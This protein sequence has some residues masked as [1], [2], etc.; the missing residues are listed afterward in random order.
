MSLERDILLRLYSRHVIG[1]KHTAFERV[2]SGIPRHLHG[3][4]KETAAQLIH[5]GL[6]LQ[7]P[8]HYGLQ[9]SLNPERITDI[10]DIINRLE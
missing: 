6:I 9:I 5:E 2:T 8:T 3:A 10:E 1:G 4:A 7:K